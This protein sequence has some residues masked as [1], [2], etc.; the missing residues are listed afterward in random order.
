MQE[1]QTRYY[2]ATSGQKG[3][4]GREGQWP[5]LCDILIVVDVHALIHDHHRHPQDGEPSG[6]G[7]KG[8]KLLAGFRKAGAA[9]SRGRDWGDKE[10]KQ[11]GEKVLAWEKVRGPRSWGACGAVLG[12][13]CYRG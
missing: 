5:P 12:L 1:K 10:R 8:V 2:A 3:G 9:A 6:R 11:R 7:E 4:E 13:S